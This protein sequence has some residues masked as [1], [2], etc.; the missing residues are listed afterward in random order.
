MLFVV[1]NVVKSIR[2][3]FMVFLILGKCLWN[4]VV[5]WRNGLM[6]SDVMIKGVV[7]VS[8][9]ISRSISS[10]IAVASVLAVNTTAVSTP[11]TQGVHPAAKAKPTT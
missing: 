5:N 4:C 3:R 11:P 9:K 8:L 10:R 2:S 7:M 1:I 6:K